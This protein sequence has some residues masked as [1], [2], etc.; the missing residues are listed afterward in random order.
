MKTT[1]NDSFA[2]T[3]I[4]MD[5]LATVNGGWA[6]EGLSNAGAAVGGAIDNAGLAVAHAGQFVGSE[7]ASGVRALGN[8]AVAVGDWGRRGIANGLDA[9]AAKLHGAGDYVRPPNRN[10]QFTA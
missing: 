4:S 8:A 3:E 7:I 6:R 1:T 10:P 5:A 9:A 2:T